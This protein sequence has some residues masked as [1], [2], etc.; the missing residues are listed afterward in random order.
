MASYPPKKNTAF[1]FY[2]SLVSQANTK[3]MQANPTLAAGDVKVAVDDAAPANLGT[4]PVVDADFTKRVKVVM[5]QAEMNGDRITVIFSDAAGAEWCDLTIDIP[6]SVR[7]VDDLCYPAISGRSIDVDATGGVEIT[8]NQN[9]NVAQWAGA[10]T[11]TDDVALATAPTNFSALSITAGGLLDIT[12][13][14]A[15]KVWS[16][17]TRTLTAFS[18]ALAVSVWDVLETAIATASS[19]GLK[20][21]NNLDAAITSRLASGNVTVGGYAAGQTPADSILVTPAN[22]LATDASNRVT[23]GSNADKTGYALTAG[24]EDAIVD[25]VWD[26]ATAG[27]QTAGTTGKALTDAGAAGDPWSTALPGAYGA[28]TAG[29][30]MGDN[31]NATVGSRSSHSAADVWAVGARTLTSFGTLVADIWSYVTRVLTAGTNIVLAKGVGVTGFNDITAAAVRT[32][33]DAAL[34]AAGTEL[35]AIPTTTGTLRQK[36]NFVFQY[37]R[38]KKTVTATTETLFKEDAATTLGTATVSDDG[39]TFTKG[40]A[41]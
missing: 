9:V 29:K 22:K 23:V 14:A 17:A 15:D 4:L 24:E 19:I 6:T 25:K 3:I 37:F 27:H 40:E 13:A 16:S 5:A 8:A 2:V 21:K 11:A 30:I 26:E 39:T 41:S 7:Q 10:A 32:E 38:N 34:D 28:G 31:L 12:Q 18:T 35:S 33:V 1:T 20:V 36:I